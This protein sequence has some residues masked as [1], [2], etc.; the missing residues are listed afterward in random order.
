MKI[1]SRL[2]VM[3]ILFGILKKTISNKR[4]LVKFIV[5]DG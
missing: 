1:R 4:L 2:L 3:G 5:A